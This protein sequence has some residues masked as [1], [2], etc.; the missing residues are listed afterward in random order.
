[1]RVGSSANWNSA[2]GLAPGGYATRTSNL[3]VNTELV[4]CQCTTLPVLNRLYKISSASEGYSSTQ[5]IFWNN[6][7]RGV[8]GAANTILQAGDITTPGANEPAQV[9]LSTL[10]AANTTALTVSTVWQLTGTTGSAGGVC[11]AGNPGSGI[12]VAF[13]MVEDVGPSG[14]PP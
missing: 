5:A 10:W 1:M 14:P 3:A 12:N 9:Y 13:I 2:W 11:Q 4:L 7:I 8:Q 6:K